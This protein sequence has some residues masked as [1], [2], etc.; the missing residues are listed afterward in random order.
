MKQ[1]LKPC[2]FCGGKAHILHVKNCKD[3]ND[4]SSYGWFV[5]CS[6]CLTSSDIYRTE[7]A[8]FDHWNTRRYID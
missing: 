7:Q 3:N 2:P 1:T 6:A 4:N 5:I 8:A